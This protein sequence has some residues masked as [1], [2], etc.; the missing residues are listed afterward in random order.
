MYTLLKYILSGE[1]VMNIKYFLDKKFKLMSAIITIFIISVAFMTMPLCYQIISKPCS[2]ENC[3]IKL[4]VLMYH[5]IADN[6]TPITNKFTISEKD[7]ENDLKYI[8]ENGYTTIF[9]QDLIDFVENRKE[10]P[11]KPIM[12]TFDDGA[13]NNYLY[14]FPLAKK[15]NA[16][17]VFSPIVSESEKYTKFNDENP[18]YSHATM[19][20]I[21]EMHSSGLVEIQNH[22]YKLHGNEKGRKGCSK[23][24]GE[25][26][27]EYEK[28]LTDDINKSQ[29]FINQ[30]IGKNTNAFFYPLGAFSDTSDDILKSLG[31]KATFTCESRV[32][33][34]SKNP[35]CLFKLGRFLRPPNISSETFFSKIE[36]HL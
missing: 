9:V 13:Y 2:S 6:K 36:K 11:P 17:F 28:I 4:P 15:Y 3:E 31:F 5:F 30:C 12:L 16:K 33:K 26:N 7:F 8:V 25:T 10:L 23:K 29:I 32:N 1:T 24:R 20:E 21:S 34:I 19:S 22:T 18:K 14:A 27:R 35:N